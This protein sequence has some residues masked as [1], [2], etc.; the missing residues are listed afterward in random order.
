M[1]PTPIVIGD[2]A[3]RVYLSFSDE[4]GVG[5]IG[6]V[7]VEA[8]NPKKILEVS[9]DPVLD[10]G[11][12]GTFDDNG[13]LPSC[14]IRHENRLFLYYIGF[15]LGANVRYFIFS[16]LAESYDGG[17]SFQ[18]VYQVP[19][20]DRRD[21]DLFFRTAPFVMIENGLYRMWYI[22]GSDWTMEEGKMLP[23]YRIK[24]LESTRHDSW[25]NRGEACWDFKSEE[26]HGF[27]RPFVIER[28]GYYRMLYS[29]RMRSKGYRL[30]YAESDDGVAW[31]RKDEQVGI[32]VSERGWDSEMMCF[33]SVLEVGDKTYMFYNG[34]NFGESGFGYAVLRDS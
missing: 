29:I 27:G 30:G 8:N 33:S 31:K 25:P 2:N 21:S 16:G 22:G 1:I 11:I 10:I 15:Q 32:D 3:I 20:L 19:I 28:E 23:V 18:R 7:E 17:Y 4:S 24:Y 5:R 14:L 13:V 26:E 6:F 34:N 12:P 9:K